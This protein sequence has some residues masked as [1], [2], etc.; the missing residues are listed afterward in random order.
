MT[1]EFKGILINKFIGLKSK[2]HCLVSD[3]D[4]VKTAKGVNISTEFIE[5]EMKRV[6]SKKHKIST[7]DVKKYYYHVLMIKDIF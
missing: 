4:T 2:R 1:E 3:D 7:Y 6:Q 5:Y